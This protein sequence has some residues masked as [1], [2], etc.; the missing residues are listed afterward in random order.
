MLWKVSMRALLVLAVCVLFGE[1][2]F[3]GR[4]Q[5]YITKIKVTKERLAKECSIDLRNKRTFFHHNHRNNYFHKYDKTTYEKL[6]KQLQACLMKKKTTT[7]IIATTSRK[8]TPKST[9]QIYKD[10]VAYIY[11][12]LANECPSYIIWRLATYTKTSNINRLKQYHREFHYTL[13][14]CR[15]KQAKQQTTTPTTTMKTTLSMRTPP[16]TTMQKVK[17][18][19]NLLLKECPSYIHNP[20]ELEKRIKTYSNRMLRPIH[21]SLKRKLNKCRSTTTSTV[22]QVTTPATRRPQ[23]PP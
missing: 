7:K 5:T 23:L 16:T 10:K 18:I 17:A 12:V 11:R 1:A 22:V 19:Y 8:T 6:T 15:Q 21:R 3:Y 20:I 9:L 13:N 14:R 2:H 4:S